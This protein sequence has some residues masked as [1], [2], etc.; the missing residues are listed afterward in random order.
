MRIRTLAAA[1]AVTLVPVGV[2]PAATS[3]KASC[4]AKRVISLSPT[5]TEM[6][7]AIGAGP[8]VIAVDDQSSFPARAPR[9]KLSGIKPNAE[10]IITRN[11]DLVVIQYDANNLVKALGAAKV[12]VVVQPAASN[13]AQS[14]AQIAQ[15]GGLTCRGPAARAVV[16]R[17]KTRIAAAVAGFPKAPRPVTY[18]HELDPLLYSASSRTFI[19]NVY[20]RLGLANVADAADTA[21]TGYPQVSAEYLLAANP[22]V[23][24][25]ADTK[26]C[27]QTPDKVAARP[28]FGTLTA[29]K[30]GAVIA[31]DD[32]IASRWGPR[33]V[34][35]VE[36]V[37]RLAAPRVRQVA[38][39]G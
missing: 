2:A 20:S 5:A 32:D 14:Y 33:T 4:G 29:V 16:T 3:S 6:L 24:F 8:R 23:I 26:C 22:D 17:M 36:A 21:G 25:L 18:Y 1:L 34:N 12:R 38:A 9:T 10:A 27:G 11:P 31:L 28:G 39:G 37:A 13:L 19:G 7:F 35:F 30:T 15:L